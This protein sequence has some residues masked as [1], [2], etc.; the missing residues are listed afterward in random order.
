MKR[1]A[2]LSAATLVLAACSAPVTEPESEPAA[3]DLTLVKSNF[4]EECAQPIVVDNLFCEQVHID[5]M[6]A[7]GS[8]LIV[9]TTISGVSMQERASVICEVVS[10]VHF[11][12]ATGDD[13]GFETVRV[14]DRLGGEAAACTVGS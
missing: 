7:D 14:L 13:L 1:A 9:P 6:T 11:D 5:S 10:R 4:T 2:L 8:I 3:F 12:G